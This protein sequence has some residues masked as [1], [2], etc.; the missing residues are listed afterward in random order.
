MEPV[1]QTPAF[2]LSWTGFL[3]DVDEVQ[4]IPQNERISAAL[5]TAGWTKPSLFVL[6]DSAEVIADLPD[7]SGPDKAFIRRL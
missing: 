7:L 6:A 2:P 4:D 1:V 5:T 3:A